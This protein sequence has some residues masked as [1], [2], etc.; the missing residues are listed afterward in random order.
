MSYSEVITKHPHQ[1]TTAELRAKAN[2]EG[3]AYYRQQMEAD[4]QNPQARYEYESYCHRLGIAPDPEVNRLKSLS[5]AQLAEEWTAKGKTIEAQELD[6]WREQNAAVW[7]ASQP[8]YSATPEN[9]AKLIAQMESRGL[10]GSVMDM[11]T[12][13]DYLVKHGDIKPVPQPVAP[14]RLLSEAEMREMPLDQLKA[15]IDDAGRK[16][17]L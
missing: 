9:A 10:R 15:Y 7:L 6:S 3:L 12:C 17:I 1:M 5:R 13:F 8:A 4:P 11:Q 14:V 16:G 2:Q